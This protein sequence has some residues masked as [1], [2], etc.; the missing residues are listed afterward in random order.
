M[1]RFPLLAFSLACTDTF[2]ETNGSSTLCN[3]N[4]GTPA[5]AGDAAPRARAKRRT[6]AEME[7]ARAA[8][9]VPT[10]KTKASAASSISAET[11]R[12]AVSVFFSDKGF[13]AVADG[14]DAAVAAKTAEI[15]EAKNA[16]LQLRGDSAARLR[17]L[18]SEEAQESVFASISDAIVED[19]DLDPVA[20]LTSPI[21]VA[22]WAAARTVTANDLGEAFSAIQAK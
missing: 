20:A 7:A 17:G 4:D 18:S 19:G 5:P 12:T 3:A 2:V 16:R 15:F 14:V 9:T 6:P 13:D 8:G 1:N 22:Y 21:A 11:K 10:R